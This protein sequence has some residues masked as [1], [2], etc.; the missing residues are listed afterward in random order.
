MED[1]GIMSTGNVENR[2]TVSDESGRENGTGGGAQAVP[3]DNESGVSSTGGRVEGNGKV[4]S[5]ESASGSV[6][7]AV[8][9]TERADE[10][11][12]DP[13][14][15][16]LSKVFAAFAAVLI[17][18]TGY[19][20]FTTNNAV[21]AWKIDK[22]NNNK[23]IA[24]LVLESDGTARYTTGSLVVTGSYKCVNGTM[25]LSMGDESELSGE[26]SY[27]VAAGLTDRSL[28]LINSAGER[29]TMKQYQLEEAVRP[30][31]NFSPKQEILGKWASSHRP[32]VTYEFKDN[33]LMIFTDKNVILTSTYF[34]D[35]DTIGL[36]QYPLRDSADDASM[37]SLEY[38]VR[39]GVLRLGGIIL[40]KV[41]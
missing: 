2:S 30:V 29:M 34:V 16:R 23:G 40:T 13:L 35:D 17:L 21:G 38:I 5:D 20:V 3:E 36:M 31:S 26:Y 15:R 8:D 10:K 25:T 33:G 18:I 14:N 41:V 27:R 19:F 37:N 12:K 24:A 39:D 7:T 1:E 22:N 11:C 28:D 32:D 4:Q 9:G 6:Q